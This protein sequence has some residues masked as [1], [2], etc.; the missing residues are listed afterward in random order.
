MAALRKKSFLGFIV[1][2]SLSYFLLA[3]IFTAWLFLTAPDVKVW[4]KKS[5]ALTAMMKYELRSEGKKISPRQIRYNWLSIKNIPDLMR[6]SVI[7]SE[8]ASF[9]IHEGIDW[10]EVEESFKKNLSRGKFLRGGSTITQQLAKN[11]Y[12]SPTK[13]IRRK[14]RE[15]IIAKK[16]EKDLTK[17]RILELYLNVIQ[18]GKDIYGIKAASAYYFGKTPENLSLN[19]M[20][21]LAAVLPNPVRMHPN[22]VNHSVFWR[23]NVILRRLWRFG[24]ISESEYEQN[25]AV[26]D[27]LYSN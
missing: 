11:L 19:E 3:G 7:V 25:S 13:S 5:P 12:L 15:W 2:Y 22:R 27:S 6:K 20:I 9:W 26:L 4:Q 16:L 8:D 1:L 14:L 17:T 23:S 18:W 24:F 10:H 21:R